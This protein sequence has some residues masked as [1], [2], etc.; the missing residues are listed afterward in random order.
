MIAFQLH[1]TASDLELQNVSAN[2]VAWAL[3][4]AIPIHQ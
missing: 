1:T 2:I 4:R 3:A